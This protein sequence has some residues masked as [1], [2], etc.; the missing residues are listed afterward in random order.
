M[1]A[2]AARVPERL[3]RAV[4]ALTVEPDQ[5]VLEIGCGRGVAAALVCDRLAGGTL[6]GLDRSATAVAA[7]GERNRGA[8]AQGRA[9]F[10][11]LAFED[12]KPAG[13]GRFDTVFAVNVNLF[14]TRPA[15]HEL[16]LVA[17]LLRPGGR[18][19]L[20]YDPPDPDTVRRLEGLLAT[21]LARA[22]YHHRTTTTRSD[23][24]RT[25]FVTVAAHPRRLP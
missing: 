19:W 17:D 20:C 11:T 8:V 15:Q 25:T 21:R 9:E 3:V 5:R 12:A 10:R 4:D 24:G 13:L 23:D 2:T 6:L 1:T 18:V 7:A 16:R 14:W 22:G